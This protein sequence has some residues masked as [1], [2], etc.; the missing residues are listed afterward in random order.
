MFEYL[1]LKY[2]RL[3]HNYLHL[4]DTVS[5]RCVSYS[6]LFTNELWPDDIDPQRFFKIKN[7]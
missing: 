5:Y 6:L 3:C 2:N 7:S 1:M 4:T